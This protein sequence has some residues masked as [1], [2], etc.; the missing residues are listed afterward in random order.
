MMRIVLKKR[1]E[2]GG[3]TDLTRN[4]PHGLPDG[5]K[6]SG[7]FDKYTADQRLPTPLV[8]LLPGTA[9]LG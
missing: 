2:I 1:C 9:E 3:I 7:V 4:D 5:D 8:G 6:G